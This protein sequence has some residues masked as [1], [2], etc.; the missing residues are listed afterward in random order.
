MP[1][2]SADRRYGI[3]DICES[4]ME[5]SF[6]HAMQ[7]K[8]QLIIYCG[9]GDPCQITHLDMRY[10]AAWHCFDHLSK[11]ELS[12]FVIIEMRHEFVFVIVA[13]ALCASNG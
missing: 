2:L 13:L 4:Y 7:A 5:S 9:V 8:E 10:G 1:V 6:A 12:P 11:A 3:A